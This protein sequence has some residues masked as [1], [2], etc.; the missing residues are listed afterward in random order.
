MG[1][2]NIY[3]QHITRGVANTKMALWFQR[4]EQS[5]FQSFKTIKRTFETHHDSIMNF[6]DNRST[7]ASAESFNSK[8]K[9]FRRVF[10]GVKDIE[11]F[12]FRLT[13]IFA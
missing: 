12:L 11:F 6:F 3:E 9:D 5:G 7:N 13:N 10:R 2:G 8:I 4:V 1:L